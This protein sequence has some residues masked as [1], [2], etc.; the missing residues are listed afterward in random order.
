MEADKYWRAG[1]GIARAIDQGHHEGITAL[2][3]GE[4]SGKSGGV[5]DL[6]ALKEIAVRA[7][8]IVATGDKAKAEVLAQSCAQR[9]FRVLLEE[10][11][12][13]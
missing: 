5:L 6:V 2:L 3:D 10:M 8:V 13:F 12:W 1:G 9:A 7:P 11:S 4:K